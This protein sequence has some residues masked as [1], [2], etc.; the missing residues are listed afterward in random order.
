MEYVVKQ[1][2]TIMDIASKTGADPQQ[3]AAVNYLSED[4]P[5]RAGDRLEIP[6]EPTGPERPAAA[7]TGMNL[8][9]PPAPLNLGAPPQFQEGGPVHEP[10]QRP[11]RPDRR[12]LPFM[13]SGLP[14]TGMRDKSLIQ[15]A[16]RPSTKRMP[17]QALQSQRG[18]A[19]RM[20]KI[21]GKGGGGGP[22]RPKGGIASMMKPPGMQ[23]AMGRP[24]PGGR[25]GGPGGP[26]GIGGPGGHGGGKKPMAPGVGGQWMESFLNRRQFR[27]GGPVSPGGGGGVAQSAYQNAMKQIRSGGIRGGNRFQHGG[28]VLPPQSLYQ[29]P[30]L[31]A[32][33][34][35]SAQQVLAS[36]LNLFPGV[37]QG[38][39]AQPTAVAQGFPHGGSV[40]TPPEDAMSLAYQEYLESLNIPDIGPNWNVWQND[41]VPGDYG[42]FIKKWNAPE[43]RQSRNLSDFGQYVQRWNAPPAGGGG[44]V[45]VPDN[46]TYPYGVNPG[47]PWD[48]GQRAEITPGDYGDFYRRYNSGEQVESNLLTDFGQYVQRWN[49]PLWQREGPYE[50]EPM[51]PWAEPQPWE[52][53]PGGGYLQD[54][55]GMGVGGDDYSMGEVEQFFGGG[56]VGGPPDVLP[57][58]QQPQARGMQ[59]QPQAGGLGGFAQR[60]Q[61]LA[62]MNP[63]PQGNLGRGPQASQAQG[64]AGLGRGGDSMLMHV[65]KDEV[66][67]MATS[68]NPETGLPEAFPWAALIPVIMAGVSAAGSAL[69]SSG[70]QGGGGI[71]APQT[72]Q[73]GQYTQPKDPRDPGSDEPG[74]S[75]ADIA[76]QPGAIPGRTQAPPAQSGGLGSMIQPPPAQETQGIPSIFEQTGLPPTFRRDPSKKKRFMGSEIA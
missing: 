34:Q 38:I 44:A 55:S 33:A 32:P 73:K 41:P 27:G 8:G 6:V 28:S 59:Q 45:P 43:V 42:D 25:P 24:Q 65:N 40:L 76:G 71:A 37:T 64:L 19:K 46:D 52:E 54:D 1:N 31:Q 48:F 51:P 15:S 63:F 18:A 72:P 10:V 7:P 39:Q 2:E 12:K 16:P 11:Q 5:I 75:D 74:E 29:P 23:G 21:Y 49:E 4:N 69:S 30:V 26:G 66:N 9:P 61:M 53:P 67:Q 35:S 3:I 17:S 68:I 57:A 22:F 20:R 50:T 47:D 70:E 56:R 14:D 62:P 60:Q 58:A 36:N 13:G